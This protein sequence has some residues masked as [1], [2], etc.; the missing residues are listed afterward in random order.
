MQTTCR[1]IAR[2]VNFLH[3]PAKMHGVKPDGFERCGCAGGVGSGCF[4]PRRLCSPALR[5]SSRCGRSSC[6]LTSRCRGCA[7]D[8]DPGCSPPRRPCLPEPHD[9]AQ[10][11]GK[12][13]R[14]QA[15]RH[16]APRGERRRP[17]RKDNMATT[18]SSCSS[19]D[20]I[21]LGIGKDARPHGVAPSPCDTPSTGQEYHSYPALVN[22]KAH[23][24]EE[25]LRAKTSASRRSR[26]LRRRPQHVSRRPL[27]RSAAASSSGSYGRRQLRGHF[28]NRR[29]HLPHNQV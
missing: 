8:A 10:W 5:G 12:H 6:R 29:R 13:S 3:R 20:W 4:P 19:I 7:A 18:F 25:R 26:A 15:S 27:S 16:S 2:H 17:P 23:D 21:Q 11:S 1:A 14:K 22:L 24:D 28:A 9:A